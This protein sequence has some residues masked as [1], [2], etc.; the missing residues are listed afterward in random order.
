[1]SHCLD[2]ILRLIERFDHQLDQVRSPDYNETQ[3]RIDFVNPMFRELGWDIDNRQ[4]Y[5]EQYREVVHED[6][7]KVA[8]ATKAPDYSFRVGGNRKFFLEASR[9]RR[10]GYRNRESART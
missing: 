9:I 8:G 4:G 1:M 6:R 3:L 5:A 10:A 7:V 2:A